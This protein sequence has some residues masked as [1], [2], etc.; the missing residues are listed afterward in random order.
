[1][2]W[3]REVGVTLLPLTTIEV[4]FFS[5]GYLALPSIFFY[6]GLPLV[7]AF[8]LGFQ[9]FEGHNGGFSE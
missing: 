2:S 9:G 7:L 4:S 3:L 1:M 8:Q 6:D 5:L